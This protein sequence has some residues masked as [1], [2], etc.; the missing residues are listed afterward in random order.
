MIRDKAIQW[1]RESLFIHAEQFVAA[2]ATAAHQTVGAGAPPLAEISTFG[3]AALLMEAAGDE[4]GYAFMVPKHWD[5]AEELGFTVWWSSGSSTAADTIDWLV[6]AKF[7]A[8]GV[9]LTAPA[10]LDTTIAQDTVVDANFGQKTSRGIK[11]KNWLTH[12][13]V[14]AGAIIAVNVEM[15]AFAVGLSEPKHFLGLEIDFMPR[16]CKPDYSS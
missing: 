8:E 14:D 5:P 15:D 9:V 2:T 11:N 4:G 1:K 10:A 7:F 13:Q 6:L 16:R 3:F 12:A